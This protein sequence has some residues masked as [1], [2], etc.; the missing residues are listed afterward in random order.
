[1][2]KT[3]WLAISKPAVARLQLNKFILI[4]IVLLFAIYIIKSIISSASYVKSS[5][6]NKKYLVSKSN[7][8]DRAA[9]ILSI[10]NDKIEIMI[11]YLWQNI[12]QYPEYD[13]YIKQLYD[14]TRKLVLSENVSNKEFT[15]YTIN[16]GDEMALCLRPNKENSQFYEINLLTY[17][18]IHE[19]A[20]IACPEEGHTKL[21]LK[22]FTFL[23]KNAVK[24][25]I[26]V[27]VNYEI[28]PKEYCGLTISENLL[29]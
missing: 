3:D 20:H 14:R 26:Y 10:I 9:Y 24:L 4:A 21:F 25:N 29:D 12:D 18:V 5:L 28:N 1:M 2:L 16:K 6:D 7:D 15:S 19:L 22:I 27:N 17:V 13:P 8:Q 11:S 23:I